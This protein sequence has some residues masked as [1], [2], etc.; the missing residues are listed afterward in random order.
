PLGGAIAIFS[1]QRFHNLG[2]GYV[3]GRMRDTGRFEVTRD[4]EDWGKFK[5]P[6]L[7]NVAM[8]PPYMHDGSI[9]TLEDVVDFY[10]RGGIPNPNLSPGIRPLYLSSRQKS[11]LVAFLRTL[12]DST[13]ADLQVQNMQ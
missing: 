12:T 2:V 9:S 6:S 1:D 7:R 3:N 11:A 5:T 4:P 13:I 8:T 10:N